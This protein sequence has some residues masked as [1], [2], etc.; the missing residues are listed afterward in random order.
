MQA[1]RRG[2]GEA[3]KQSLLYVP[4]GNERGFLAPHPVEVLPE[5]DPGMRAR[6]EDYQLDFI[7]EVAAISESALCAVFGGEG[8]ILRARAQ[9]IDPRPVLSPERQSEFHLV[10]TLASDTNDLAVL[11]PM[12]RMMSERLGRRLRQ[13]GLTAGRLRLAATYADYTTVARSIPLPAAVL[14]TELWDAARRAFALANT[15][16]LA[17]RAVALTLDRLMETGQ[18]EL[19]GEGGNEGTGSATAL[20]HAL[21]RIQTRYGARGIVRA[22]QA[23]TILPKVAL[24]SRTRCASAS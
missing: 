9:G 22:H 11:H 2:S 3:G 1:G 15:K 8:R 4:S 14:D 12:L 16:R 5:L 6:L 17:L 20:Q 7:G 23:T 21:D 19:W 18:L 10:H 24:P 13:R